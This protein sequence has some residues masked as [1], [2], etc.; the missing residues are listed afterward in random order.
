MTALTVVVR[1]FNAANI[2]DRL[3]TCLERL[4]VPPGWPIDLLFVDNHSTDATVAHIQARQ[5]QLPLPSR[6]VVEHRPGAAAARI[7]GIVEAQGEFIAFLDE[8][9]LPRPDWL[10]TIRRAIAAF[11]AAAVLSGRILPVT[12]CPIPA[13]VKPYLAFYALVDRGDRPFLYDDTPQKILPPGAGLIVQRAAV[14]QVLR[15]EVMRLAGPVARGFRLKGE[16]VE[17][18]LKLRAQGHQIAYCPD[19][20]IDHALATQRFTPPYLESFLKAVARP[21][22]YHRMLRYPPWLWLPATLGYG[23]IDL[24]KWVGH[25]VRYDNTVAWRLRH[26]FLLYLFISPLYTLRILRAVPISQGMVNAAPATPQ[27]ESSC[28]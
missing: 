7:R 3:L 15:T 12:E 23:A 24:K 9:N 26:A 21:R 27:M 22:H 14:M 8:D 25:L 4:V 18:L 19:I 5:G 28:R 13:Y 10:M 20:V 11:P 1:T 16:D 17:L 2:I 6:V